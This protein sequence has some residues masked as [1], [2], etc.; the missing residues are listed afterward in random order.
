MA[1]IVLLGL[2]QAWQQAAP[3]PT[4]GY[5]MSCAVVN[6][7]VYAIGGLKGWA[8]SI[9]PRRVVEA[10][11]VAEDTWLTDFAPMPY[12]RWYCG[13]AALDGKIYVLGG[14]DGCCQV[15]RVDRFDPATNHWDTVAPMPWPR[16]SLSACTYQGEIYAVGGFTNDSV[17][18]KYST[19]VATFHSDSGIGYWTTESES[20]RM[21]RAFF[22]MDTAGGTIYVAGGVFYSA[23]SEAE[24][25]SDCPKGWN[26]VPQAMNSD[27]GGLACVGYDRYLCALGGNDTNYLS[28]VEVLDCSASTWNMVEPLNTPRAYLG[29]AIVGNEII[30]IGGRSAT[31]AIGTVETHPLFVEGICETQ[32]EYRL[33]P[34]A[35]RLPLATVV[36][37]QIRITAGPEQ[38]LEIIDGRG[39]VVVRRT[40]SVDAQL[41]PG[42]YFARVIDGPKGCVTR[43]IVVV[44]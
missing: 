31:A 17:N 43:K 7:R 40:R 2:V 5:G 33:P 41:P 3:M 42:V 24:Y 34:T 10:Y 21:P 29:A 13:C 20:L 4:P 16:Q 15:A 22:G 12:P 23:I 39:N 27:R 8:D 6:G 44:K 19:E 25:Y 32:P 28:S 11:D 35:Y 36:R 14:T 1:W 26:T 18:A 37:G 30:A 9:T 38:S